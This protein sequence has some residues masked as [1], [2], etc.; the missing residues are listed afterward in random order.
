[1][2]TVAAACFSST[3]CRPTGTPCSQPKRALGESADDG[4][5]QGVPFARDW[6]LQA[7]KFA[8]WWAALQGLD[9]VAWSTPDLHLQR[10]NAYNPPTEVYQRA[11][12][13][14]ATKLARVLP[15]QVSTVGLLRRRA[16]LAGARIRQVLNEQGVPVCRSFG[17]RE[18][19]E[20]FADLA[21]AIWRH[22]LPVC[23]LS[24]AH[25]LDRMPLFGVGD[26]T[27]WA[28]ALNTGKGRS[29]SDGAS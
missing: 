13:E 19:A 14:A 27:L 20:R 25:P 1:M 9:G 10:W 15:L 26:A 16:P 7:L 8:L 5:S 21:G 22:V 24:G 17:S 2:P 12:P 18:Q 6:P 4:S 28:K 29:E 23:W 11:L 3:R